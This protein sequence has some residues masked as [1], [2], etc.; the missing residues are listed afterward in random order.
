[1]K[2]EDL[3]IKYPEAFRWSEGHDK[4]SLP[5][6]GFECSDGW[7]EII[8]PLVRYIHEWNSDISPD[9][10]RIFIHQVKEKFAGLRF[11]V[12]SAPEGLW[13]LIDEAEAK[14]TKIC[15]TCG[16]EGK[17]RGEGWFYTSCNDHAKEQDKE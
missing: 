17:V 9:V 3:F 4:Y 16:K 5:L 10:E 12:S 1:M 7:Y 14:S 2:L 6:F 11:Y 8:E 15:E 13:N